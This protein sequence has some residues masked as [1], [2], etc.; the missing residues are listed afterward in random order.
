MIVPKNCNI[1]LDFKDITNGKIKLTNENYEKY[2]EIANN[3]RIVMID[4]IEDNYIFLRQ[5]IKKEQF[6]GLTENDNKD[7]EKYEE[8]Y[9]RKL[10]KK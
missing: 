4:G 6:C 5:C 7:L 3:K 2:K 8:I 9:Q 1:D 10:S